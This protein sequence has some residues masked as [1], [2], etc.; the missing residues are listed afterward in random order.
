MFDRP[1]CVGVAL[2]SQPA[3]Q[4]NTRLLRFAESMGSAPTDRYHSRSF[5]M[6]RFR[7]LIHKLELY[8]GNH[9]I[10]A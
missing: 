10:T 5:Y 6:G 2:Y 8:S 3:Q 9:S 7:K 1:A 4:L